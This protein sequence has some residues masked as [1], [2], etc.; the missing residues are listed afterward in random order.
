MFTYSTFVKMNDTDAAGVLFFANIFNLAHEA[1]ERWLDSIGC[2]IFTIL[3]ES[4]YIL[5][6]VHSEADYKR[7]MRV[8]DE[9]NIKISLE[10]FDGSG[11]TLNYQ[12][13]DRDGQTSAFVKTS[14]VVLDKESMDRTELTKQL[15]D[16]LMILDPRNI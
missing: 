7:P 3:N 5:P 1:Y 15:R 10:S 8:G 4:D 14:H 13:V 2:S 16:A 6:I 12:F 9:I 11:Y